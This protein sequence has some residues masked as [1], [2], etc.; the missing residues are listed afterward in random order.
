MR[1]GIR[2]ARRSI[3]S[4]PPVALKRMNLPVRYMPVSRGPSHLFNLL[5]G[6][7]SRLVCMSTAEMA[8]RRAEPEESV[9]YVDAPARAWIAQNASIIVR[10][11]LRAYRI[12]F[13]LHRTVNDRDWCAIT[14]RPPSGTCSANLN[15]THHAN[16]RCKNEHS[17]PFRVSLIYPEHRPHNRLVAAF[18]ESLQDEEDALGP[19]LD[20]HYRVGMP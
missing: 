1:A 7:P 6:T 13:R 12:A 14:S 4:R 9:R 16:Y 8:L 11:P 15:S 2:P 5:K 10:W 3:L 19:Y 17:V 18:A 20:A